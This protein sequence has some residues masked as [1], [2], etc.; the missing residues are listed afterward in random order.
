MT[1][2]VA[3]SELTGDAGDSWS[4]W[5]VSTVDTGDSITSIYS[6]EAGESFKFSCNSSGSSLT[7]ILTGDSGES[8]ISG[9]FGI[10]MSSVGIGGLNT[11][12]SLI[13]AVTDSSLIAA[14]ISS[15]VKSTKSTLTGISMTSSSS[16]SLLISLTL[17]KSSSEST[18][19]PSDK[20]SAFNSNFFFFWTC[21]TVFVLFTGNSPFS[22]FTFGFS[23][24]WDKFSL[25]GTAFNDL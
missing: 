6:G 24:T 9:G 21:S 5:I 19:S 23:V 4:I 8:S 14:A 13:F 18:I 1:S 20:S 7:S 17:P 22:C 2:S 10:S 25:V 12:S 16:F 15:S 3:V 11:H